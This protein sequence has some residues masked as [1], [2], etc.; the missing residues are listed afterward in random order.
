MSYTQVR[1]LRMKTVLSVE[2]QGKGNGQNNF[3][4]SY[5]L[6]YSK[7]CVTFNEYIDSTGNNVVCLFVHNIHI[8]YCYLSLS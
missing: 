1:F 6:K 3:V 7:D 2:T 4:K 8:F 5:R